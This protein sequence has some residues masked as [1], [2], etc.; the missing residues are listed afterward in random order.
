[1]RVVSGESEMAIAQPARVCESKQSETRLRGQD[2][3]DTLRLLRAFLGSPRRVATIA[4][5]SADLADAIASK[6]EVRESTHVLELGVGTGALTEAL[7]S[8]GLSS[9]QYTG[10][11]V[12]SSLVAALRTKYPSMAFVRESAEN[13]GTVVRD[14]RIVPSHIVASLPWTCMTA[15]V[16]Q[17]VLSRSA[18]AL[19]RRGSFITYSY[20]HG[21]LLFG[22]AHQAERDFRERFR[23]VGKSKVIWRNLPP[24]A[25]W[26]LRQ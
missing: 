17:T 26:T 10:V 4:P 20:V 9:S 13:L 25:V 7:I 11:E 5:S 1:M 16:R 18:E 3:G 6:V 14:R 12:E 23:R 2:W 15:R 24:A 8:K 22:S 19:H 21:V